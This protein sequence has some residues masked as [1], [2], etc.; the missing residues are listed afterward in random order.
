MIGAAAVV[1]EKQRAAAKRN[2]AKAQGA[3]RR[4]RTLAHLSAATRRALGEEAAKVRRGEAP[5]RRELE[6][7]ARRLQIRGRSRM[8][9]A[10]LRQAVERA[11]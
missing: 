7:E 2:V 3:A 4:K 10:E 6:D 9:K 11:R 1:S 8:G 5:S